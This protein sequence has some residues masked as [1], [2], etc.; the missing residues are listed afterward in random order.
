[1]ITP[2]GNSD[3]VDLRSLRTDGDARRDVGMAFAA[4]RRPDRV[5]LG[6]LRMVQALLASPDGKA[7][8]DDA[9]SGEEL[10]AGFADG[11]KWRGTVTRSLVADGYASIVGT[12]RSVR[13]ARH[14]GYVAVLSLSDRTAAAEYVRTITAAF[15]A[16]NDATSPAGTDE[17][18]I[19]T[20]YTDRNTTNEAI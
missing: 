8:I 1:M 2:K 13:P 7:T 9:T 17:V 12:T 11:G 14:R 4:A 3:A 16:F 15:A 5:T 10:T 18:A 19:S 20:T 6:R